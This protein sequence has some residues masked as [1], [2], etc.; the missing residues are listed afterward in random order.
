LRAQLSSQLSASEILNALEPF[1]L[2]DFARKTGFVKRQPQKITPKNFLAGFLKTILDEDKSLNDL[3][4]HI[5]VYAGQTVSKQAVDKRINEAC[6]KYFEQVLMQAILQQ[7]GGKLS[8]ATAAEIFR[9]FSRVFVQD[10]TCIPLDK[11]AVAAFPGPRNQHGQQAMAKIQVLMDV[12]SEKFYDFTLTPFTQND[13]SMAAE[14]LNFAHSGDLVLRDLGYFSLAVLQEMILRGIYFL[15]R[16]RWPLAIFDAEGENRIDLLHQLQEHDHLDLRVCLG[17]QEKAPARLVA[18]P[19][20]KEVAEERRREA[21]ADRDRRLNHDAEYLELL[22]WDIFVTNVPQQWWT[23]SQACQANT[24]RW[25]IEIV[26]KSW[27]SNFKI[28]EVPKG[29][30]PRIRA[31]LYAALILITVYQ[32]PLFLKLAERAAQF[33]NTDLSLMK[34]S[35]FIKKHAW[36][37][38]ATPGTEPNKEM[39]LQQILYHCRYEK[40]ARKNYPQKLRS[41]G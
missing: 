8:W 7:A 26:F 1:A 18:Q 9:H 12:L 13:Q 37:F 39:I 20:A 3:A 17:T 15:S 14:I 16:L 36:L 33:Y 19:V 31:H 34:V 23:I 32:T 28:D 25:R 22:G 35:R 2:E 41:F 24:C 21:Q 27:K 6:V 30:A 38:F 4:V 11:K 10:S 5:G 40:R 29:D